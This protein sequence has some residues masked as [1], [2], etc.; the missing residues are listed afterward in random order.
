MPDRIT[1]SSTVLVCFMAPLLTSPAQALV[2]RPA[3]IGE[4][5][6]LADCIVVGKVTTLEEKTVEIAPFSGAEEKVKYQVA[7]VKISEALLDAKKLTHVR[8]AF[9]A[10]QPQ[11]GGPRP[12]LRRY[13]QLELTVGKEGCFFLKK[14]PE[15]S[16]YLAQAPTD[17]I[18][19]KDNENFKKEVAEVK[20]CTKLLSDPKAGLKS[21][22]ADDRLLTAALLIARYRSPRGLGVNFKTER[23]DADQ[24][25]QILDALARADWSKNN[26][27][28]IT[29]PVGLFN[30]L[31]VEAKDGWT[32]P[33]S[34]FQDYAAAAKNWVQ[35]HAGSYRI[36]RYVPEKQHERP[37][38]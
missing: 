24:S 37:K 38:D 13:P 2:V 27:Q 14:H 19:Q 8:V 31:G 33:Q 15:E 29:S 25:K 5:A 32:S 6:A 18:A 11:A 10:Q 23:I 30:R 36:Q 21:K 12:I 3:P 1:N 26:P 7:V 16:F 34:T 4:R 28:D 17:F 35:E 22:Q 9:P 20:R